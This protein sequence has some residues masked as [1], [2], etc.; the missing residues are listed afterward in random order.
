MNTFGHTTSYSLN[1]TDENCT[2]DRLQ[3]G[4]N[5]LDRRWGGCARWRC[6]SA[7]AGPASSRAC[8]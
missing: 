4:S 8:A 5:E 6:I 1:T 2:A 3:S 7:F